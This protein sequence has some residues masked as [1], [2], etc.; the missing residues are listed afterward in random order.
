MT[1]YVIVDTENGTVI[2]A[3]KNRQSAEDCVFFRNW[4]YSIQCCSLAD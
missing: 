4:K 3:F 2:G 1:I